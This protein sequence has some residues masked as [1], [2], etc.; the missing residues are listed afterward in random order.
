MSDQRLRAVY[1]AAGFL[2]VK[3]GY[4]TTQ[5]SEIAERANIGTGT[6]YNLFSGKKSILHFVLM[7]TLDKDYLDRDITL[8]I[9]EIDTYV[10]I[11]LLNSIV[12]E[13]FSKIG[14]KTEDGDPQQSFIDMLSILFDYV[15]NYQVAFNII[16]DNPKVLPDVENRYNE[17]IRS[18]YNLIEY[19]LMRYIAKGE[20]REIEHP[21]LHIHN[22]IEGIQ[23]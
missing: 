14:S 17:H 20:I 22:I 8:P 19:S 13:L 7:C 5:V 12:D 15:A 9:K 23:E 1:E 21:N 2:L 10:I 3:K 18:L 11:D 6:V 4:D 16:N